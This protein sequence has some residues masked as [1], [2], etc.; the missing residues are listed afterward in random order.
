MTRTEFC[1]QF[2][3]TKIIMSNIKNYKTLNELCSLQV[4]HHFLTNLLKSASHQRELNHLSLFNKFL[5][6]FNINHKFLATLLK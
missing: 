2:Y 3:T 6:T 4:M 1:F 5:S